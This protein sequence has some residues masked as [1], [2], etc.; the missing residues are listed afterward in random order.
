MCLVNGFA[1]MR[2]YEDTISFNPYLPKVWQEYKF[3]ITYKGRL[4]EVKVDKNGTSYK[5]LEGE[6]LE[7]VHKGEKRIIKN[8]EC[9]M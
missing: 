8:V 4:I 2:V 6:S 9:R 7:I 3:K 1:G 5:L